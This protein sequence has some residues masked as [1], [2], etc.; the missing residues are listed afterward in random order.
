MGSKA[1]EILAAFTLTKSQREDYSQVKAAFDGHFLKKKN[2]IF[3]RARF[4][5]RR[6]RKEETADS[7]TT[8]LYTLAEH[9]EFGDLHDKLIRDRLVVG[10]CDAKLSESLQMDPELTLTQA[11]QKVRQRETVKQ[12]QSVVRRELPLAPL[13]EGGVA[14]AVRERRPPVKSKRGQKQHPKVAGGSQTQQYKREF[15]NAQS[16]NSCPRCGLRP[17]HQ[18]SKCPAATVKCL[19]CHKIGHYARVCKTK[20]T[21]EVRDGSDDELFLSTISSISVQPRGWMIDIL[22]NNIST[23]MK[24]DTGA[25]VTVIAEPLYRARFASTSTLQSTNVKLTGPGRNQLKVKGKFRA[26]VTCHDRSTQQDVFVVQGLTRSLLGRPAIE[27]LE[28]LKRI[29]SMTID[30]PA[31]IQAK[32]PKLFE[33]LGKL[34]GEYEIQLKENATPSALA[35]PRRIPIP[36]MEAVEQELQRMTERGVIS[37]VEQPTDWCSAMVVVPKPKGGVRICVDLTRLNN[38][39]KRERIILPTVEHTL[40]Q[41]GGASIFTKLDANSGFWQIPLKQESSLLTTFI[42]PFGRFKFNRLPFGI[43]SAPEH[44]QRTMSGILTGLQGVVCQMD[45]ILVY[46]STQEEHDHRLEQVLTKLQ[47]A[48]ITL[49]KE[50]CLFSV[51]QVTFLGQ[52]IDQTGVRSDPSKVKAILDMAEPTVVAGVRRLLGMTNHLGKFIP[53]L[54][55]REDQATKESFEFKVSLELGRASTNSIQ[56]DQRRFVKPT[57]SRPLNARQTDH[58]FSRC[59]IL[60]HWRR[61]TSEAS[62]WRAKANSLCI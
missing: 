10:I 59:I 37:K 49:N 26:C 2:T 62:E 30:P 19:K 9:C 24:I 56:K 35:T 34:E 32:F 17:A 11:I 29:Q 55:S 46:G 39:V 36:L 15:S 57:G 33:G 42:T 60:W 43:S 20:S 21:D 18:R 52:V 40:G 14:D 53:N 28:I 3:E 6:Q 38:S 44:F 7:F 61:P 50:K 31:E 23:E 12:Q 5:Q 16:S 47:A 4:N 58:C 45:D 48:G 27:Q 54:I 13:A 8:D 22:V 25:D 51:T 1:E 41:L